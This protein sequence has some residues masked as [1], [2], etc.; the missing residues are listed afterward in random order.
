[1]EKG[2]GAGGLRGTI[3]VT[4]L[5]CMHCRDGCGVN[6][7]VAAAHKEILNKSIQTLSVSLSENYTQMFLKSDK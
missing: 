5:F 1:M 3:G 2:G 4:R 6:C 7:K